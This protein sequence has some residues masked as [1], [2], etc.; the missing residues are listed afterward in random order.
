MTELDFLCK[1][2][3][4]GQPL[5]ISVATGNPLGLAVTS[6]DQ[7]SLLP[8]IQAGDIIGLTG[9]AEAT[10]GETI[11]A[12]EEQQPLPFLH[13]DEPTTAERTYLNNRR[14]RPC[15]IRSPSQHLTIY[16]R[17]WRMR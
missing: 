1:G 8:S 6:V 14:R 2:V 15:S 10:L 16:Q 5:G 11:G 9:I 7:N 4:H 13:I 3:H 17:R 12:N